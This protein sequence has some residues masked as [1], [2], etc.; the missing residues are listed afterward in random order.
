MRH[1]CRR[2]EMQ[3]QFGGKTE[4]QENLRRPRKK[5]GRNNIKMDVNIKKG[6]SE[7]DFYGTE[8]GKMMEKCG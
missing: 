8:Q 2:R 1:A 6:G 7:L 5:N 3:S 4:G